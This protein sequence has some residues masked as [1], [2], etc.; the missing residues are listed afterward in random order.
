MLQ[1]QTKYVALLAAIRPHAVNIVDS[2]DLRDEII[3]SAL[4]CWDGNVYQ[5]IFFSLFLV[6]PFPHLIIFPIGLFD[7]AAKSP[8]NQA[9][10]HQESFQKYLKPL[11]KSKL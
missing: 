7:E 8:L 2:F 4:G 3:N 11:L 1:L 9:P 5:S 6:E 10:V